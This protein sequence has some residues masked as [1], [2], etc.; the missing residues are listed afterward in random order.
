V[1]ERTQRF[2]VYVDR[3]LTPVSLVW[4]VVSIAHSALTH[5]WVWFQRAGSI[6]TLAG[7]VLAARGLTRQA[8]SGVGPSSPFSIADIVGSSMED[9]QP[10]VQVVHSPETL[11]ERREDELDAKAAGRGFVLAVIGTVVWGYGDLVGWL[12]LKR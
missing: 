4:F 1:T 8:R 2:L 12:F 7:V 3:W 11:A 6:L 10:M 9:G 5:D